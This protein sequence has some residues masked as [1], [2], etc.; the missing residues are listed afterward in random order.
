MKDQPSTAPAITRHPALIAAD[1]LRAT[2]ADGYWTPAQRRTLIH[3]IGKYEALAPSA[4]H[5]A[6]TPPKGHPTM[7]TQ[8]PTTFATRAAHYRAAATAA[9]EAGDLAGAT[10]AADLAARCDRAAVTGTLLAAS[11]EST[12]Y[13]P[14]DCCRTCGEHLSDPHAPQ[15]PHADADLAEG[16][17]EQ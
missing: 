16:E 12:I 4:G 14:D 17:D 8:T 1:N 6:S 15:C 5:A 7:S 9:G 10:A 13:G 11:N 2:L 3:R